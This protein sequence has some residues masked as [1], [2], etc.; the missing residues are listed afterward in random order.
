MELLDNLLTDITVFK[1]RFNQI[2]TNDGSGR[3]QLPSESNTTAV[4]LAVTQNSTGADSI[5]H[6]DSAELLYQVNMYKE[7]AEKLRTD[8]VMFLGRLET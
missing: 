2:R 8:S 5:V 3:K 7:M 1:T 4:V 6:K